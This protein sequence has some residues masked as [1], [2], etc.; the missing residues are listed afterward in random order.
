MNHWQPA[1]VRLALERN[2]LVLE[3]SPFGLIHTHTRV[4]IFIDGPSL[5]AIARALGRDVDYKTLLT[6]FKTH[7]SLAAATYF[8]PLPDDPNE[9]SPV[10]KLTDFLEYNG[11]RV[12][13]KEFKTYTDD[14]GRR[15]TKGSLQV[16]LATE[17]LIA[18]D[19]CEYMVIF[20]GDGALTYAVEAVQ[21]RGV[22]V[23]IASSF[24]LD[25]PSISNELRRAADDFV[26]LADLQDVENLVFK[27]RIGN[28]GS[29]LRKKPT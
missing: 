27:P 13:G 2:L 12:V 24:K 14:N 17:M 7:S 6:H 26:E 29:L 25:P 15:Q 5:F 28:N 11:Y 21:R 18:S 16:E 19:H 10:I 4:V 20:T 8:T 3:N 23:C 1:F 22:R 9:T